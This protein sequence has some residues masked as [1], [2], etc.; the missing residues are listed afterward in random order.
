MAFLAYHAVSQDSQFRNMLKISMAKQA[1][2]IQGEAQSS[3]TLE[4]WQKRGALATNVLGVHAA[5]NG[6]TFQAGVDVYL[7]SFALAV[8]QNPTI[9]GE[10][11]PYA[12]TTQHDNDLDFQVAAVWSDIAGV[13]GQDLT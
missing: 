6:T 11:T 8:A 7:E 13:T 5:P 3:M 2:T 12:D 1:T 4:E 10:A 9:G